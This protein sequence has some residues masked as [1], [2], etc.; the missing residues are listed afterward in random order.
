MGDMSWCRQQFLPIWAPDLWARG[1]LTIRDVVTHWFTWH[2]LSCMSCTKNSSMPFRYHDKPISRRPPP[3]R[4]LCL[5]CRC[6]CD[7]NI[8][9]GLAISG[10][11]YKCQINKPKWWTTGRSAKARLADRSTSIWSCT[12]C[13]VTNNIRISSKQQLWLSYRW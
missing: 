5:C 1:T 3:P 11:G 9:I 2:T 4:N 7:K 8:N 12:P 6:W 10:Y 13:D